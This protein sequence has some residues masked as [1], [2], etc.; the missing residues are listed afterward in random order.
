MPLELPITRKDLGTIIKQVREKHG[1]TK[2]QLIEIIGDEN[3]SSSTYDRI[4]SGSDHVSLEKILLV[5]HALEVDDR[6][7]MIPNFIGNAI[8]YVYTAYEHIDRQKHRYLVCWQSELIDEMEDIESGRAL[9]DDSHI[10]SVFSAFS[11]KEAIRL[12]LE[13]DYKK[14]YEDPE[15]DLFVRQIVISDIIEYVCNDYKFNYPEIEYTDEKRKL[16]A[17]IIAK[18]H[19]FFE[20]DTMSISFGKA[21]EIEDRMKKEFVNNDTVRCFSDEEIKKLFLAFMESRVY[22]LELSSPYKYREYY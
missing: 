9:F 7:S 22:A 13:E 16:F 1:Y 8:P 11:K 2:E 14:T 19:S 5:L 21:D 20:Y 15:Y 4:E 12:F 10:F 17:K 18:Y 3:I 6:E